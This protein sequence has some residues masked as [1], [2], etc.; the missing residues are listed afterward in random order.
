M[1]EGTSAAG[2]VYRMPYEGNET[3]ITAA[4]DSLFDALGSDPDF[5]EET[6]EEVDGPASEDEES[7]D[8]HS[9]APA[10]DEPEEEEESDE[11]E[12][13][14]GD[15]DEEP[16]EE[17]PKTFRVKVA[18]EETE[19]TLDELLSGYSRTSDYTRKTQ[20]L[21]EQ[22]K[23]IES[24]TAAAR[25]ARE[26]YGQM[27]EQ[28]DEVL[29][30]QAPAEPDWD[31]LRKQNPAEFAAQWAEHQ[32]FRADQ[33]AVQAERQRI[34]GEL[35]QDRAAQMQTVL[36]T[37]RQR[38]IEA[39]P[40]WKDPEKAKAEKADLMKYAMDLGYTEEDLSQV[41]DHRVMLLVRKA[42]LYDEMTTKGREKVKEKTAAAKV[43]KPGA[44]QATNR[45]KKT[46]RKRALGKLAQTGRVQDAQA[47]LLTYL[48]DD[49]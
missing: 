35:Q 40:E 30:A 2:D 44:P 15:E 38:L 41:Y 32:R 47:A 11:D 10:E 17:A 29:Q 49:D 4:T 7:E 27:L 20:E 23:A 8:E 18:G 22:R 25:A 9:E 14:D 13:L 6:T 1:P 46:A 12:D 36:N 26:R 45:G 34:E 33:A 39:I 37:E 31:T 16:E 42:K 48:S 43:L 3:S 24:E 21:A 28:L 19:V 5:A